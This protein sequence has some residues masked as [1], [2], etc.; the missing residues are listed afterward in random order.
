MTAFKKITLLGAAVAIVASF[1]FPRDS[2]AEVKWKM[3]T[4]W[5]GGPLMEIGAKALAQKIEFLTEGRVK[6]QVFPSG[7]LSKGL[8]VRSAVRKGV[9]EIGHTWMGYDWGKDKT[10]VLTPRLPGRQ[11]RR[12]RLRERPG[13][14][15][16]RA[17]SQ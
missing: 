11:L 3:A 10:T 13:D 9:A 5:G 1:A 4:S 14:A 17:Q 2:L 6:V 12:R 7:T 8:D 15:P 16:L